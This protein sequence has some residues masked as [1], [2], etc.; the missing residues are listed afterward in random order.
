MPATTWE[1][2]LRNTLTQYVGTGLSIV[3]GLILVPTIIRNIGLVDF[4][5]WALASG[6]V[7]SM[8]LLDAGLAP[9]L[10]KKTAEYLA[11]NDEV[12]LGKTAGRVLTLYLLIGILAG[13][14][15]CA[16]ALFAGR[17]F[18]IS[19]GDLYRFRI[20]LVIVAFQLALTFPLSTWNGITAG[21]QDFHF[22]SAVGIAVNLAKFVLTIVLLKIGYG[23][24][25]LISLGFLMTCVSGLVSI[26]WVRYRVPTLKMAA[27]RPFFS[28]FGGLLRFSGAM[29]IW[30]VAG[31]ILLESPRIIIGVFLPVASIGIYE[32]GLRV[33]NYSRSI[34]YPMFTFLPAAS[35]LNARNEEAQLQ[36]LYLIGTKYFLLAYAFVAGVILLFGKQFIFLWLGPGFDQSILIMTVLVLGTLYQSQNLVAH[37]M[38]PGMGRVR[39]FTWIMCAY[40]IVSVA[41]S[42][43]L[44]KKYG[45]VGVALGTAGSYLLLETIFIFFIT[46]ILKVPMSKLLVSC[47]FP[48]LIILFP[49]MLIGHYFNLM[50]NSNSWL[51]LVSGGA[52]FS[53][54][55]AG[56]LLTYGLSR[57][58]RARIRA[59]ASR[60]ILRPA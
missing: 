36:E 29:F 7:G 24:L 1:K 47:H 45:L 49:A 21:L 2:L 59:V 20:V 50:L 38:L 46:S 23:L 31:R 12:S 9:T 34:L 44:L 4:G 15:V 40:P 18:H 30:A 11:V 51:S 10:T 27:P 48:V 42:I 22:L 28:A 16:L 37:V 54:C 13:A 39:A 52:V 41:L 8:G 58:E 14:I 56:A 3:T 35:D 5:L 53:V 55:F 33:C 19:A 6:L 17:I 57:P 26:V 32:V 60:L 25:G 43:I